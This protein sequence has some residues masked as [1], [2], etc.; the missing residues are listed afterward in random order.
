[1]KG[2]QQ[3]CQHVA[4]QLHDREEALKDAGVNE[5]G[6]AYATPAKT[7][8]CDKLK[9]ARSKAEISRDDRA[10]KRKCMVSDALATH[11]VCITPQ[12]PKAATDVVSG[13]APDGK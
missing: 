4:K 7:K 9:E 8:N 2:L 6:L 1:M 5:A 3:K 13:D 11:G 12:K 10:K